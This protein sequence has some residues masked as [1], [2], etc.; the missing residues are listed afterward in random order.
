MGYL[1]QLLQRARLPA[2]KGDEQL[3][4]ACGVRDALRERLSKLDKDSGAPGVPVQKRGNAAR[5]AAAELLELV[6]YGHQARRRSARADSPALYG[7]LMVA[8]LTAEEL[9]TSLGELDAPP[10]ILQLRNEQ[11]E[12]CKVTRGAV[13]ISMVERE[14]SE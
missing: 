14:P 3:R 1:N 2:L 8:R 9:L 12:A 10:P 5:E 4:D 11:R 13:P 7:T 6:T